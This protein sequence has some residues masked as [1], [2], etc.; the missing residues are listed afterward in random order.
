MNLVHRL[1]LGLGDDE[2]HENRSQHR[3]RREHPK[4]FAVANAVFQCREEL[5][6][7][8]S[9]KPVGHTSDRASGA[10]GSDMKKKKN[11]TQKTRDVKR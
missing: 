11:N 8:E 10:C 2:K 6:D 4:R 7:E 9:E 3:E 1:A 5:R